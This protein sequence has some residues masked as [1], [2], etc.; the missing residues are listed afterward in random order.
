[1]RTV[2]AALLAAA[3][4][5]AQDVPQWVRDAAAL[6]APAYPSKVM[7][8]VLLQEEQVTVEADGRRVM[9]E[10]GAVRVLQ[11]GK[12]GLAAFRTYN[13]KSGK[14]R[15]FQ[16]W[17]LPPAGR[18]VV[19]P[20]NAAMDVALSTEYTYDEERA[21]VLE[22]GGDPP[23]GSIFAWEIVE[24]EKTVFTQYHYG[25]QETSPVLISRFILAVPPSWEVKGTILNHDPIQPQVTGNTY[26]WELR[27]LPWIEPEEYR[28]GYHALAPRLGVNYYP[29]GEAKPELKPIKDWAAA[30]AWLSAFADPA[31]DVTDA[32]R[33]KA[34]ELTSG[35]AT[36]A[37]KIRAIARFAQK[38]NY[39]SVQMNIERGGGYTPHRADDVLSRNYGDCKDKAALTR[40]L[41]GAVGINSYGVS[42]FSRDREFVRPEWPTSLQFNH[43]I[44]AISVSPQTKFPAVIEHPA[45]G[46]LLIFD[47]TDPTT[48]AGD[49]PEE[50]QGS[51]ALIM[52]GAKGALVKMPVVPA[53]ANRVESAYE[54]EVNLDGGLSAHAVKQYFGQSA[55]WIRATMQ[56]READ[57]M[58]R[59]FEASLARKLGGITLRKIEPTDRFD[60][61]RL[62]LSMEFEVRK[63]GQS[64][65][66]RL[67]MVAPGA[68]AS[69]IP[70]AFPAKQR[71]WPI[72]LSAELRK[73]SVVIKVPD[74][75]QVD[76]LPEPLGI[77]SRYGT[78]RAQWK[79]DGGKI[80]F[81][82]SLVLKDTTAPASE[83]A[84]VRDFFEKVSSGQHS[85][86]VLVKK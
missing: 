32:I 37:D 21:R 1:M 51:N 19:Y 66:D 73:D 83:Y 55:G 10:R 67:L 59:R 17:L 86:V 31:A 57:A 84:Q 29:S 12:T 28:P 8:L 11:R 58:K 72:R 71:T 76:E 61:N 9:R 48:P 68:L 69:D 26:T 42:I 62:Q 27:N 82:Q 80:S 33:S 77:E 64:L 20:K 22:P 60:E 15:E 44:V 23:P 25:F 24:E 3:C 38:T 46:R 40:A 63:F 53:E 5:A 2:A 35:A 74:Q 52:A 7:V 81:E 50:E 75:Y 56:R 47:P 4:L 45:L 54:G 43:A 65:Q 41:L 16:G 85:A 14:I 79:V 18:T 49:L 34:A 30:S 78:Y 36:E 39:V 13:V 6:S 70:Y